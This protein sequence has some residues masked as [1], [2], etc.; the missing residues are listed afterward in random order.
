MFQTRIDQI[1]GLEGDGKQ[2]GLDDKLFLFNVHFLSKRSG[3]LAHQNRSLDYKLTELKLLA[4]LT[5][6]IPIW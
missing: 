5:R 4:Q 6:D 3:K 1:I 2:L